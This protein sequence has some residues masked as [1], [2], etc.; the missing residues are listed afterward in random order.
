MPFFAGS[1]SGSGKVVGCW[2]LVLLDNIVFTRR[3][4]VFT[5]WT[6]KIFITFLIQK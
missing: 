2:V 5:R 6:G 4:I 1:G 3:N